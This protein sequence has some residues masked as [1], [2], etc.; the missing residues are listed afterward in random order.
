[1]D[2]EAGR[3][4]ARDAGRRRFGRRWWQFWRHEYARLQPAGR[5]LPQL[6]PLLPAGVVGSVAAPEATAACILLVIVLLILR[7]R[8]KRR[9]DPMACLLEL[10]AASRAVRRRRVARCWAQ[11]AA[12]RARGA[13]VRSRLQAAARVAGL[14][15]RWRQWDAMRASRAR[16]RTLR[17]A[18]E[19]IVDRRRLIAGW[20]QWAA[21]RVRDGRM[22]SL[23]RGA[24]ARLEISELG[25]GWRVW[26]VESSASVHRAL[27]QRRV[28]E[29]VASRRAA[30]A[31]A[32]WRE[33]GA[34]PPSAAA[35]AAA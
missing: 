11:W 5:G 8:P 33:R 9:N 23:L 32:E 15:V 34:G 25:R 30:C 31:C 7:R 19:R 6:A 20:A 17:R 27:L 28:Y 26:V 21:R 3:R 12:V 35:C 29:H 4:R 22:H 24:T 1:M 10:R 2:A 14:T 18:A 13:R 16:I